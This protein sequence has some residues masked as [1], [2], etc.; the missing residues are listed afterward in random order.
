MNKI[1]T[2]VDVVKDGMSCRGSDELTVKETI[3]FLSRLGVL[4]NSRV[5][6]V[7]ARRLYVDHYS[8]GKTKAICQ[9]SEDMGV[10]ES[11][12]RYFID[13]SQDK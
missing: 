9:V 10:P 1:D 8:L 12:V 4:S 2:L 5:N 11:T 7:I 6:K 13:N 3:E